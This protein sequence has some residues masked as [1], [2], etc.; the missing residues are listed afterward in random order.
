MIL[1]RALLSPVPLDAIILSTWLGVYAMTI[2]VLLLKLTLKQYS[3][4]LL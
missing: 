2:W 3:A 1:G 4:M